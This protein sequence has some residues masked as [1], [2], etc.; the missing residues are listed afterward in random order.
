MAIRG[1]GPSIS[2]FSTDSRTSD[3]FATF[4][5]SQRSKRETRSALQ[6]YIA[7]EVSGSFQLSERTHRSRLV[8]ELHHRFLHVGYP[9]TP[10]KEYFL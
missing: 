2:I 7:D 9:A 10:A 4:E 6:G 1:V 8:Y 3:G 5:Q